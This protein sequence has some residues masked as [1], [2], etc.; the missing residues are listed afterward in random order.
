MRRRCW[1]GYTG[2]RNNKRR[3]NMRKIFASVLIGSAVL[4]TAAMAADSYLV[5]PKSS[6]QFKPGA[7]GFVRALPLL[8]HKNSQANITIR[9][10]NGQA[11]VHSD[12]E[13]HIFILA[14]EA[15][16]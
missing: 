12:W 2:G 15:N 1:L 9:D 8:N 6:Q 5:I 13:D 10:K 7:G 4:P 11:E 14:G 3:A 16:L